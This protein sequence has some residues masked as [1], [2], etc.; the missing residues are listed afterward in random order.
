M[1]LRIEFAGTLVA[2]AMCAQPAGPPPGRG[3]MGGIRFLGAQPGMPGRV[4]KNAPFSAEMVTEK[5]QTL[6]DG[7]RI[8]QTNTVKMYRDSDGRTRREQTLQNL[9]ALAPNSNLPQVVF[10]NDPVAGADFALNPTDH[11]ATRSARPARS[12]GMGPM[13]QGMRPNA[14]TA[15]GNDTAP[16][17]GTPMRHGMGRNNP[18]LKRESLGRQVI[19][20]VP[21]DGTRTTMT[22]PAGE[23]GNEQPLQVVNEMWYSPDLQMVVM[24]KRSDPRSGE[25]IVRLTNVS[26][27]EPPRTMFDVPSDYKVSDTSRGRFGGPRN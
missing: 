3:P 26:R 19:E 1:L 12:N 7:N 27:A 23:I 4:V 9:G 10:I 18:N 5:T 16:G 22:I 25:T 8:H 13:R 14:T 21:A 17:G 15:G 24:S 2:A 6:P 11:T 20:G